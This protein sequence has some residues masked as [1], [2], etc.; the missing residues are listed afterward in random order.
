MS[1]VSKKRNPDMLPFSLKESQQANP[2]QVPQQGPYGEKYPLT[3]HFYLSFNISLLIFPSESPSKGTSSM[4]PNG[5]PM[6]SDTPS[7]EPLVYFLLI[8]SCMYICQSPQKGSVLHTYGEKHKVTIHGAPRRWKAY[9]QWGAA[10]FP[11]GIV[12][13]CYFYPS[14]MRPLAR[15]LPPWLG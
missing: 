2:L 12:K 8:N 9:I 4:F 15:Y 5:V 13:H 11:K 14:A 10:W 7:P 6:D 3:G 1:S